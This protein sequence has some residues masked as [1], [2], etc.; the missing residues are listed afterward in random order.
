MHPR[1]HDPQIMDDELDGNRGFF[2]RCLGTLLR[3]GHIRH[4]H[5]SDAND[6]EQ[7]NQTSTFP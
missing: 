2:G 3:H 1:D 5:I 4:V 6:R 7:Q